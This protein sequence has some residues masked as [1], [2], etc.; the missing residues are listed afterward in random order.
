MPICL[1]LF[2]SHMEAQ[3]IFKAADAKNRPLSADE[4]NYVEDLLERA[5]D[6]KNIE[7]KMADLGK[8]LGPPGFVP[9]GRVRSARQAD[10]ATSSSTPPATSRSSIPTAGRRRGARGMVEVTSGAPALEHEGHP[11]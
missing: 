7:V 10:P 5:T 2:A 3:E 6:A 9:A 1:T 11:A 4:R 8:T